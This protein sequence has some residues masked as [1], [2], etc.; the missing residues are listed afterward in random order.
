MTT[1]SA[2]ARIVTIGNYEVVIGVRRPMIFVLSTLPQ[3]IHFLENEV[4]Q[5]V[6]SFQLRFTV[7]SENRRPRTQEF[8]LQRNLLIQRSIISEEKWEKSGFV[9]YT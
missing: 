4:F 2:V 5:L 7:C 3:L 8:A 1:T 9:G 6:L